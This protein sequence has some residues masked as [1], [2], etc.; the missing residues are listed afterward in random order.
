MKH[1]LRKE[2]GKNLLDFKKYDT[3]EIVVV[4]VTKSEKNEERHYVY[5]IVY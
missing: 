1:Y 3:D 5:R 2:N 4:V